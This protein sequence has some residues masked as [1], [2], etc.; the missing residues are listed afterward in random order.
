M[1]YAKAR[2]ILSG[3]SFLWKGSSR[4]QSAGRVERIDEPMPTSLEGVRYLCNGTRMANAHLML[5]V[6]YEYL[7]VTLYTVPRHL[8]LRLHQENSVKPETQ[9]TVRVWYMYSTSAILM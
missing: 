9:G 5:K 4:A 1:N 7:Y 2:A 8:F 3:A 6:E